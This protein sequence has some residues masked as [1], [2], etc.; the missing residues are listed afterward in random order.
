MAKKADVKAALEEQTRAFQR[1]RRE[2]FNIAQLH[3]LRALEAFLEALGNSE[4]KT[5][6]NDHPPGLHCMAC[7]WNHLRKD[8]KLAI[9]F[10]LNDERRNGALS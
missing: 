3:Q 4:C 10:W 5:I 9:E 8:V 2:G 6:G 1:A 7:T